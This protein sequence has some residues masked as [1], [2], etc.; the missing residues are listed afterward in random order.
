M[1]AVEDGVVSPT[2]TAAASPTTG[3]QSFLTTA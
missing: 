1:A 2:P 3:R